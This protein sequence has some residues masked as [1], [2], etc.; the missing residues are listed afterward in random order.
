MVYSL[1]DYFG[2][3]SW[4]PLA[5]TGY[6][7]ILN[8]Y[9]LVIIKVHLNLPATI[10]KRFSL[11]QTIEGINFW[12]CQ[13]VCDVLSYFFSNI[14][15]RFGNKLYRQIVGILMSTNCAPLVANLFLFCYE[16]DCMTSLSDDNQADTIDLTQPLDI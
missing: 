16:P 8:L 7:Y 12:T 3:V 1:V 4:L 15:I 14:Y 2:P 13:H 10:R 9:I 11:L 5:L 6:Q